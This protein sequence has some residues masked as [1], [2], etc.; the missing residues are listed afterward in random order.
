M[1]L[2]WIDETDNGETW[3][4]SCSE[5]GTLLQ[6]HRNGESLPRMRAAMKFAI[7]LHINAKHAEHVPGGLTS[8]TTD[9]LISVRDEITEVPHRK[10]YV[11]R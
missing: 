4:A 10:F 1:P 11:V 2:F 5:C 9:D 3:S 7:S 6:T 8:V